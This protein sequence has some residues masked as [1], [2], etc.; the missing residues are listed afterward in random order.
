MEV[1]KNKNNYN[2]S[3][4][5]PL[6]FCILRCWLLSHFSLYPIQSDGQGI[7]AALLISGEGS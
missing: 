4:I 1:D 7:D 3:R 6:L 2:N 5:L